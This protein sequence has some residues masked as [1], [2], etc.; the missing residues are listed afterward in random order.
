MNDISNSNK[1]DK[2]KYK[3]ISNIS[4]A[5]CVAMIIVGL[6][7]RYLGNHGGQAVI[8]IG[9]ILGTVVMLLSTFFI[10]RKK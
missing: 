9:S 7:L 3:I 5:V 1:N 6:V 8:L 2:K 4:L 10:D